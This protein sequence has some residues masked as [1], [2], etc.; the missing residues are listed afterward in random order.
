[1]KLKISLL[2]LLITTMGFSQIG[3]PFDDIP[4]NISAKV[5]GNTNVSK[6]Q[7]ETYALVTEGINIF[8]GNWVVEGG[9]IITSDTFGVTIKW[10]G[11]GSSATQNES[12]NLGSIGY[13]ATQPNFPVTDLLISIEGIVASSYDENYVHNIVYQEPYKENELANVAKDKKIESITYYD[14]LG[15]PKQTLEIQHSPS[16]KDIVTH[17]QYDLQG[18]QPKKYLPFVAS[19]SEGAFLL[20][21]IST[22]TKVFYKQHYQEDFETLAIPDVNAYSEAMYDQSPLNRIVQQTAPGAAWKMGNG[23]EIKYTYNTNTTENKV[24]H[25]IATTTTDGDIYNTNLNLSTL[26]SGIYE[27]GELY[28]NTTKDENWVASDGVNRTTEEFTDGEGRIVLKRAY[29]DS[30]KH[31]TYYVYDEYGNISF[32][33]P[34]KVNVADGI[35][36]S[37][38]SELC[39]Q[40]KYDKRN[41]LVEKKV[42]S[43]GKE[44]IIYDRL[45]RPVLT[46]DTKQSRQALKEWLFT[47]YDVLGRV[48]YTGILYDNENRDRKTMQSFYDTSTA[49]LYENRLT[50]PLNLGD[51]GTQLYYSN[52]AQ[53]TSIQNILTINY[54]DNYNYDLAGAT[55]PVT[56]YNQPITANT[57]A[58]ATGSKV[59]VL[60]TKKWIT[61]VNYYDQKGRSIYGYTYN[62][63]LG[64]TNT[65]S[66]KLD[67]TG[68]II[69]S[70]TSHKR[71]NTASIITKDKFTYDHIGRLLTHKQTINNQPEE[72]IVSNTYNE[73]G[74]L[75]KKV[76]GGS[77][78]T[79]LQQPYTDIVNVE[80]T[81]TGEIRKN[82]TVETWN[83]GT[84]TRKRIE[85]DG[86]V[87][88]RVLQNNQAVMVGLSYKNV[89]NHHNTIDYAMYLRSDSKIGIYEKGKSKGVYGTYSTTDILSIERVGNTIYYQNNG[90]TFYTSTI[91]SYGTLMGDVC[92]Y[93][94]RAGIKDF[95]IEGELKEGLQ[96][97]NYAYNVRGW[98]KQINNPDQHL[99]DD[100]FALK[101]YYN[102]PPETP[103]GRNPLY[104]GNISAIASRTAYDNIK[105]RY[106]FEY[107]AL[108][109]LTKG[110]HNSGKY[111][112]QDLRYDKNGNILGLTRSGWQNTN[113]YSNMDRL[114]YSYD[115]GN[116]LL[117]VTDNGNDTYGFKDGTNTGDDYIYD[118]NGN[119]R[120][121]RNK[122]ITNITYNHLNLPTV[123][124]INGKH[125]RYTY[126]ATGVKLTK[127]ADGKF[128]HYDGGYVYEGPELQFFN[129]PEGYVEP[130]IASGSAAISSF[131]YIYQYKDH[132]D[133][134]RL[135]YSDN[136]KDGVVTKDEIREENNYYPFGLKHKGYN[137]TVNDKQHL[138]MYNA[139]EMQKD[140]GFN[141]YT[142]LFRLY[143]PAIGRFHQIDPLTDFISGITP[144]QFGFNNPVYFNDPD[145]LLFGNKNKRIERKRKRKLR[146]QSKKIK[147]NR[148]WRP[149]F[150]RKKE[151][152][153]PLKP[154]LPKVGK[155]KIPEFDPIPVF[156]EGDIEDLDFNPFGGNSSS[157]IDYNQLNDF[158]RPIRDF[159]RHNSTM[160]ISIIINTEISEEHLEGIIN[161]DGG[162]NNGTAK[163]LIT[164]RT[165][166]IREALLKL[167]VDLKQIRFTDPSLGAGSSDHNISIGFKKK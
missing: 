137:T 111:N 80:I 148:K 63:Y 142:T 36:D 78:D 6:D 117:K 28:K 42:P 120:V 47:K 96:T 73:L 53:P 107:D 75:V 1:M 163:I 95:K 102:N 110:L 18:R 17:I 14:A 150:N 122:G 46:Q 158:L 49:P 44:Y 81:D 166:A 132:L 85:G 48:A 26:N 34:P 123:V 38:L 147:R 20:G 61:T 51:I 64:T 69:E 128:T 154:I 92:M 83:S 115:S 70:T 79:S 74:I 56:I 29:N 101:L 157:V 108:N 162:T 130:V 133:N 65:I 105:R 3:N 62:E 16:K 126:D 167:G 156:E 140:L 86:K 58:L 160:T 114:Q 66:N 22:K 9:E 30:K 127:S 84:V 25:F 109:R 161:M 21:D 98:L 23:H 151:N 33:I 129:Q 155:S 165:K 118:V 2:I 153:K 31:D 7:V 112:V 152:I 41:R 164:K 82:Y 32:V 104:N 119:M 54:Y 88:F 45:D 71:F 11:A 90:S 12:V 106:T 8:N 100:L 116:K 15:R 121:D 139:V 87:S 146:K 55:N 124:T 50:S 138:F 131:N 143:D 159:L 43:K 19:S 10:T 149:P 72:L 13:N 76:I 145:G 60:G 91:A 94:N 39:Y 27:A 103:Q 59:R 113:N 4:I 135:S 57:K 93:H 99:T 136:N 141:L 77:T 89:N 144:Y 134:I 40:Y 67:F 5:F 35:S 24:Y 37:E 68:K 52:T 125:I 97:I